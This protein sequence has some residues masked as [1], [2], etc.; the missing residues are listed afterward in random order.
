MMIG[1][2][3]LFISVYLLAKK[4]YFAIS[5]FIILF[6]IL[7]IFFTFVA[8]FLPEAGYPPPIRLFF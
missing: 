6:S 4:L 8:Y 2:G 1:L 5:L 3:S 7:I